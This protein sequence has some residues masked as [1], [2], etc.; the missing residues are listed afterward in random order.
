MANASQGVSYAQL[1]WT[2]NWYLSDEN[3]RAA[4]ARIIDAHPGQSFPKHWGDGYPSTSDGQFFGAGRVRG[5]ARAVTATYDAE[6][7]VKEI[8]RASCRESVGQYV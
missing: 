1:A 3:Y 8:R 4:L 7:G 6:P 5:G 2:H